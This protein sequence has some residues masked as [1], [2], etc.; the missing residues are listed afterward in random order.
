VGRLS[1]ENAHKFN[2]HYLVPL[3]M[4]LSCFAPASMTKLTCLNE[5]R[6]LEDQP[7]ILD[8]FP[9]SPHAWQKEVERQ[10][11]S[12]RNIEEES[13]CTNHLRKSNASK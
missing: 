11:K 7:L 9:R 5:R 3:I 4:V 8:A 10:A 13:H 2:E 12:K 6:P 1:R